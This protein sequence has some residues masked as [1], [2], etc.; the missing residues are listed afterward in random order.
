M[1]LTSVSGNLQWSLCTCNVV[2]VQATL[3]AQREAEERK[4]QDQAVLELERERSR[5][6]D[7]ELLAQ[8]SVTQPEQRGEGELEAELARLEMAD[9]RHREEIGRSVGTLLIFWCMGVY[10]VQT[11]VHVHAPVKSMSLTIIYLWFVLV[12]DTNQNV[13]RLKKELERVNRVWS[14]KLDIMKK[15]L[16]KHTNCLIATLCL[17]LFFYQF[18]CFER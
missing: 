13:H 15:K 10:T 17:N 3:E 8:Q 11:H 1:L 4:L 2:P 9:T 14:T 7:K 12:L 5:L 6:R 16:A 18:P